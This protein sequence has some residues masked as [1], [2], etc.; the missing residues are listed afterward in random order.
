M[1][2][3]NYS[4]DQDMFVIA[5]S[6]E[7]R[8]KVIGVLAEGNASASDL[9]ARTQLHPAQVARHLE[10]LLKA[11]IIKTTQTETG[12]VYA[13]DT[14]Y[15]E[16]VA[17][18]TLAASRKKVEFPEDKYTEEERKILRGYVRS[19]GRL[20]QIPLQAKKIQVISKYVFD[21]FD[22]ER[23][24]TEKEVNEV[25][26]GFHPDTSTLRRFLV[27][28]QFLGRERDGSVYWCLN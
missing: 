14:R 11:G 3:T 1:N 24:Y 28:Y 21:A 26:A 19:D 8:L 27:D 4:L 10:I 13:L 17:R 15:V 20:S 23:R 6:D 25:L 22:K 16:A 7:N 2:T 12:I 5:L 18:Q 9:S